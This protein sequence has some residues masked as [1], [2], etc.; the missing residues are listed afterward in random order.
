LPQHGFIVMSAGLAAGSGGGAAPEAIE[1]AR[2]LGVDLRGHATRPLTSLLVA[3]ADY[4]IA[5]T[6]SH[7]AVLTAQFP[8]L[9]ARARLLSAQ[10]EDLLDP[11]GGEQQVYRACAQ[12]IVRDLETLVPE[13]Q[14]G[15][16]GVG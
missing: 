10:G 2:E 1:T 12:Q 8:D 5:M 9:G 7:L 14:Q 6:Q 3:Q 11:I 16:C 13:I 15:G 4:L